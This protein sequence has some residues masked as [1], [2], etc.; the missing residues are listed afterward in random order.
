MMNSAG[1]GARQR[2]RVDQCGQPAPARVRVDLWQRHLGVGDTEQ[3][4]EQQQILRVGIRNLLPGP[5][6]GGV[7]VQVGHAGARPQQPRD[8]MERDVTGVGFAEGPKHLDAAT[9][10]QRRGLPSHPALTDA[11][12]SHHTGDTAAAHNRAVRDGFKRRHLP[13]PTD[14]AGLGTLGQA[15]PAA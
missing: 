4:I 13:T 9:G 12:R 5:G 1:F 10:R 3:I 7:A 15:H 11:R 14:Q 8:Q 6:A 2:R